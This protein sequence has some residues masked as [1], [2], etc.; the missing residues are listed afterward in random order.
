MAGVSKGVHFS[1]INKLTVLGFRDKK[2]LFFTSI[3]PLYSIGI[4]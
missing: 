4:K 3:R 2:I 1:Y